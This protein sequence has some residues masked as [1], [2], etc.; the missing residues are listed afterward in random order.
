MARHPQYGLL[1]SA[2]AGCK[3][4]TLAFVQMEGSIRGAGARG[5]LLLD[6]ALEFQ[7]GLRGWSP[8]GTSERQ[9]VRRAPCTLYRPDESFDQLSQS[10]PSSV[11]LLTA[12]LLLRPPRLHRPQELRIPSSLR[13]SHGV[14]QMLH[15]LLPLLQLNPRPVVH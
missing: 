9:A 6:N 7:S 8:S 3:C 2:C 1:H 15:P 11:P 14:H 10:C 5:A 13:A 12:R 4:S